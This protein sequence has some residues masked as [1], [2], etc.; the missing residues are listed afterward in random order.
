MN[1]R[2]FSYKNTFDKV[3]W[4]FFWKNW[5]CKLH[6]KLLWP[7]SLVLCSLEVLKTNVK[8]ILEK[9][10][11]KKKHFQDIMPFRIQKKN[12]NFIILLT[13][14]YPR[15]LFLVNLFKMMDDWTNISINYQLKPERIE[16]CCWQTFFVNWLK[17]D[18]FFKPPF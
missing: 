18:H 15:K 7:N 3:L 2:P 12:F 14:I 13:I 6:F 10:S 16:N 5:W 4:I 11:S 9:K 8:N 1:D 17:I